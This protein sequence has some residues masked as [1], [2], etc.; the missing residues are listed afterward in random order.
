MATGLP[1]AA[2][3]PLPEGAA[4]ATQLERVMVVIARASGLA[5]AGERSEYL[6]RRVAA[7]I[8]KQGRAALEDLLQR[9]EQ[10]DAAAV[11]ELRNILTVNYTYF[12]RES[13]H[14]QYLLEH[15]LT[16][17]RRKVGAGETAPVLH[18]LSA[19][20]A[21]GE[22]AWSMAIVAAEALRIGGIAATV[23]ILAIDIDTGALA[24]AERGIYGEEVLQQLPADLRV[25]Y[26]QEQTQAMARRW[27]VA[28]VLR[29]MV[30]FAQLDLLA[31]VWPVCEAMQ[32]FD[33]IFCRN[34]MIYLSDSA[35]LH[36]FEKF[37]ALLRPDG[38]VFLSRVEGGIDRAAPYFR[39][40]GDSVYL[41]GPAVRRA[42]TDRNMS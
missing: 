41:P 36:V 37:A 23:E 29:H 40:C 12:W 1:L 24:E 33:A 5:A 3:A 11:Q 14:F 31:G 28:D 19:G 9:A 2:I 18:L 32:P 10:D 27:Q 13:E 20:C 15:L 25:R 34:V 35:R 39:P 22:E 42:G 38:L 21:S 26:L 8:E 7:C 30:R 16:Q 6:R 4:V 17:L